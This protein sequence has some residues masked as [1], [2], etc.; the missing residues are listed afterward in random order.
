MK[1]IIT[2]F[3]CAKWCRCLRST[4]F[5]QVQVQWR[6]CKV[7]QCTTQARWLFFHPDDTEH[8]PKSD[9]G[10]ACQN[11]KPTA[12][13]PKNASNDEPESEDKDE[14]DSNDGGPTYQDDDDA[15]FH[16]SG[17]NNEGYAIHRRLSWR[18]FHQRRLCWRGTNNKGSSTVTCTRYSSTILHEETKMLYTKEQS[19]P[20]HYAN[21]DDKEDSSLPTT[22]RSLS[23]MI[24]S[25]KM[26]STYSS[27]SRKLLHNNP[28][29][30]SPLINPKM[31]SCHWCDMNDAA[32]NIHSNN[33]TAPI[34]A[35]RYHCSPGA[36]TIGTMLQGCR[37]D[38]LIDEIHHCSLCYY[39]DV[40]AAKN[41]LKQ[42]WSYWML[43]LLL[44]RYCGPKR[45]PSA[46]TRMGQCRESVSM[47]GEKNEAQLL[48]FL[49]YGKHAAD[50]DMW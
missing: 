22:I 41:S 34:I 3:Q 38:Q 15:G 27:S 2:L 30:Q 7:Y 18:R 4:K 19:E 36:H 10:N 50:N 26:M 24:H 1:Q 25:P 37:D 43:P 49:V 40:L 45:S 48:R 35:I 5:T 33:H 13:A 23:T 12:D 46:D 28:K 42:S 16:H 32:P 29:I 9:A 6:R 14:N 31:V 20:A 39:S 21:P 8:Q 44:Q 17:S 47:Q 11:P